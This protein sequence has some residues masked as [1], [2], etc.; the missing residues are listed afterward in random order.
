[1]VKSL[2]ARTPSYPAGV[3]GMSMGG[4]LVHASAWQSSMM[5]VVKAQAKDS[6]DEYVSD[7]SDLSPFFCEVDGA[8]VLNSHI[9]SW[10]TRFTCIVTI[11]SFGTIR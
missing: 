7:L 9:I 4:C 11:Q 6:G 1:M 3:A 5:G 2:E 10:N 8:R